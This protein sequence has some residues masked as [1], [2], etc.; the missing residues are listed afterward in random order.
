MEAKI[1]LD[2]PRAKNM[3]LEDMGV[4]VDTNPFAWWDVAGCLAG[5]IA[6]GLVQENTPVRRTIVH[7]FVGALVATFLSP[8]VLEFFH[9]TD[10]RVTRGVSF[11]FGLF[12]IIVCRNLV[13]WAEMYAPDVLARVIKTVLGP[14]SEVKDEQATGSGSGGK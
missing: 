10:E 3:P 5:S 4:Q 6:Y 1:H 11:I 7:V 13:R 2:I 12:G 9:L 8:W 14:I